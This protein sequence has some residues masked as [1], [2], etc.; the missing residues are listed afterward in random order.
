MRTAY[1]LSMRLITS[2]EEGFKLIKPSV[3][4]TTVGKALDHMLIHVKLARSQPADRNRQDVIQSQAD[5]K[6]LS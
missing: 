4:E 1:L 6:T 3:H 5:F 2:F